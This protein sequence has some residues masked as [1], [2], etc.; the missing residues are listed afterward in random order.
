MKPIKIS[1]IPQSKYSGYI[2]RSGST[3]PDYFE[4]K[5]FLEPLDDKGNDF[6]VEAQLWDG[7]AK[8]SISVKYVDG[9]Y[10]ALKYD[11]VDVKTIE[12][13]KPD[14]AD[15][16]EYYANRMPGY[17]LKFIQY[18]DSDEDPLCLGMQVLQPGAIVFVGL[19][20]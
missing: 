15:I 6:I 18:W 19:V 4:S 3:N 14:D 11:N 7:S 1:N 9:R 12:E 5:E 8:S 17:K 20:K 10:I 2:W 13:S 16:V